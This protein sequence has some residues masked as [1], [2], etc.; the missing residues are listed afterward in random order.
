MRDLVVF[1]FIWGQSVSSL[2]G[3]L[4][5]RS[6]HFCLNHRNIEMMLATHLPITTEYD[7]FLLLLVARSSLLFWLSGYISLEFCVFGY[8]YTLSSLSFLSVL[9]L[10]DRAKNKN[11]QI[12]LS[13]KQR[14]KSTKKREKKINYEGCWKY[15]KWCACV[16]QSQ[17]ITFDKLRKKCA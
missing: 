17:A 7:F 9:F 4:Y 15:P 6:K 11:S 2:K 8:V 5:S 3:L 16:R 1:F 14:K 10:S 12:Y 13:K